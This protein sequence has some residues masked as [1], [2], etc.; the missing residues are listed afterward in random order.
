[1]DQAFRT[2]WI[3]WAQRSFPAAAPL[4]EADCAEMAGADSAF[5]SPPPEL[6]QSET[7]GCFAQSISVGPPS[8]CALHQP[9][10]QANGAEPSG[11]PQHAAR[12]T[13]E[14][15][16]TD[17]GP[18]K[19]PRMD[20]GFQRLVSRSR[21]PTGGTA[22]CARSFQSLSAE[23]S[24][25]ARSKV[26]AGSAGIFA[27]FWPLWLSGGDPGGQWRTFWFQRACRAVAFERLVDSTG[28]SSGIYCPWAS[29]AEWWTRTDA[30]GFQ[31]RNDTSCIAS[32][33]GATTPQRSVAQDVQ[34]SAATR[35]FGPEGTRGGLPA[36][37]FWP[38]VAETAVSGSLDCAASQDQW[39]DQVE[40][41]K[42]FCRRGLRR[43][44]RGAQRTKSW[45]KLG[46]FCK[47][48]DRRVVGDRSGW[49][50][51]SCPGA[52]RRPLVKA[53]RGEIG[54]S[55]VQSPL[56]AAPWCS[57]RYGSLRSPPLREHQGAAI[58][59]LSFQMN[60]SQCVTYV[61]AHFVTHVL[62]R[63]PPLPSPKGRGSSR[64]RLSRIQMTQGTPA[65]W[66]RFSLSLWERAGGG[67][68]GS[69]TTREALGGQPGQWRFAFLP[70]S[71]VPSSTRRHSGK[72]DCPA[73]IQKLEEVAFVGLVP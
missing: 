35:S 4:P 51:P 70:S 48:A 15:T 34:P 62:A 60:I 9:L 65:D 69:D 24:S 50:A 40:G 44:P 38:A 71:F 41:E 57:L 64:A 28:N 20:G 14:A 32:P 29:R 67:G 56:R 46:L 61:L 54:A 43:V 12:A 47:C 52:P 19:Q 39:A 63:R 55:L 6:G 1:M 58:P 17:V 2:R 25:A 10:P 3:A 27:A 23:H 31:S 8:V 59:L 72:F 16:T 53:R 49:D 30:W 18:A 7:G 13:V 5:A 68:A 21:W 33:Q 36:E 22:D 45:Q 42:A 37:P 11:S 26:G 66:R 73:T